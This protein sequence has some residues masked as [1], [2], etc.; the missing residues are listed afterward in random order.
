LAELDNFFREACL[1]AKV[2]LDEVIDKEAPTTAV[3]YPIILPNRL[4]VILKLANQNLRRYT[5]AVPQTEVENIIEQLGEDIKEHKIGGDNQS[6]FQKMYELLL[7]KLR[8]ICE[9]ATLK[10]WC[11]CWMVPCGIS[12]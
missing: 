3:I 9:T 6:R 12:R 11:L 7:D 1:V 10:L 4:E 2:G 5:T 8:Q